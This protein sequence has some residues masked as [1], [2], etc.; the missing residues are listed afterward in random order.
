MRGTATLS[1]MEDNN[2]YNKTALVPKKLEHPSKCNPF[3][4]GIV[5]A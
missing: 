2:R 4:G 3:Q 1:N 5:F